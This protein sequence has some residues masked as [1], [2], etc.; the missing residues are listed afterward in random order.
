MGKSI[1][2]LHWLLLTIGQVAAQADKVENAFP[3]WLT[4][5]IAVAVFLFLLFVTFLVNKAWCATQSKPEAVMPN[6]YT[7][8]NGSPTYENMLAAVRRSECTQVSENIIVHQTDE[9]ITVM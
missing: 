4:G 2:V 7:M 5:I 3:N 8:T 6:E 1:T 9:N